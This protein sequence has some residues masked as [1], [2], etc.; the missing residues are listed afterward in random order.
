MGRKPSRAIVWSLV[1]ASLAGV[2]VAAPDRVDATAQP[3]P[4]R[5]RAVES[6]QTHYAQVER[7]LR[8]ADVEHLSVETR[9]ARARALDR[10]HSYW[11]GADFG[12]S[13]AFPGARVPFFV[14]DAGRHCAVADLLRHFGKPGLVDEVVQ[15]DN[16][17]FV[18]D[19]AGD[20]RV[21][22]A[23]ALMGLTV[24]EAAR[25][26]GP[27]FT[28]PPASDE[29]GMDLDDFVE[30]RDDVEEPTRPGGTANED[31]GDIPTADTGTGRPTGRTGRGDGLAAGGPQT[32]WVWWELNKLDHLPRRRLDVVAATTGGQSPTK[33]KAG[34]LQAFRDLATSQM[35]A[36]LDHADARVRAAA[37]TSLGRV[38]GDQAVARLMTL[39]EDPQVRV[40][41]RALLALGATG[42]ADAVSS[43][44][45]VAQHGVPKGKSKR[46]VTPNA[47][48]VA[49]VALGIAR[50]A[51]HAADL[52]PQ[53][54]SILGDA[55]RADREAL[56][57]SAAL[58]HLLAPSVALDAAL[59]KAAKDRKAGPALRS[60]AI[61]SLGDADDTETLRLL[62]E[63]LGGRDVELRRAAAVSLG[64]FGSDLV[65]PRLMTAYELEREPLTRGL[66]LLSLAEQGGATVPAFLDKQ[67]TDGARAL[68]P[69][70]TIA[71][72]L[73]VRDSADATLRARIGDA[74]LAASDTGARWIAMGLARDTDAVVTL[75]KALGAKGTPRQRAYA[76]TS[77]AL[78]GGDRARFELLQRHATEKSSFVKAHVA[79]SLALLGDD[80]DTAT[81]LETLAAIDDPGL[82]AMTAVGIGFG[83]SESALR[84]LLDLARAKD[85]SPAA[86]AATLDAIGILLDRRE[87]LAMPRLLRHTNFSVL[88]NWVQTLFDVTL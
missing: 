58:H 22:D 60:R 40:R 76:A 41:D 32:W 61:E 11:T 35:I 38:G 18:S 13:D 10:F 26:Q 51:G 31:G 8:A 66:L 65:A 20:A 34:Q 9:A 59:T 70:S 87:E 33:A 25:I 30:E 77:L 47:R 28:D 69:W 27:V 43:L 4:G 54:A 7:E 24:A 79:Q 21:G 75:A 64:A 73:L 16:H 82:Q 83:G 48:P 17:A 37:A 74:E 1:V 53:I 15:G 52:G 55:K 78:I 85:T 71:A 49:I 14:D 80:D 36:H 29:N 56:G 50:Q 57:T 68:R 81:V 5:A 42:S 19:L 72:G 39:L 6:L 63:T 84:G 62:Q 86:R 45:N 67:L 44:L 23:L 88:P 46:P 3:D 2:A 12:A